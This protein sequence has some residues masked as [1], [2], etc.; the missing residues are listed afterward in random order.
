MFPRSTM[1]EHH[2]RYNHYPP[3]TTPG[4]VDIAI[5][6]IELC[7]QGLDD[8]EIVIEGRGRVVAPDSSEPV[9]AT[10][11]VEHWHLEGFLELDIIEGRC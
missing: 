7:E 2:L 3:I 6:A 11:I 5:Q 10:E 4:A 1:I 8:N 9:T